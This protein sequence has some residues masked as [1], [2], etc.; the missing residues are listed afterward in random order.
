L[1]LRATE[2]E[3]QEENK[4]QQ[5]QPD[6]KTRT[7]PEALRY[8]NTKNDPNDEIYEWNEHEDHPPARS[9]RDLAQK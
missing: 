5:K 7:F 8:I 9:S 4:G 3:D 1:I 6:S 2:A